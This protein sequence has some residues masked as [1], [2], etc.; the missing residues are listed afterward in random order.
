MSKK[1]RI[2]NSYDFCTSVVN[3]NIFICREPLMTENRQNFLVYS[4]NFKLNLWQ[5]I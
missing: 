5:N 3:L 2:F 4:L 1:A